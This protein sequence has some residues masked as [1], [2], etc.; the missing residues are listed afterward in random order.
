VNGWVEAFFKMRVIALD[1]TTRAGSA[2]L[3]DDDR[4]VDQRSGDGE[5]THALRL[6][7]EILAI[8]EANG[9]AL[10][11]VDLYAVAS[12][13]GSFTGLRIGIATIQGLAFVHR[14]PTVAVTALDAIAHAVSGEL[15]PGSVVAAWMDAHRHD[16]FAA[17][18]RVTAAPA[19]T[20]ERLE[21]IEG[22]TVGDPASTLA[23]WLGPLAAVPL[24]FAGDG[25]VMYAGDISRAVPAAHIVPPP[26]LAGAV[27]RL[28]ASRASRGE[29]IEPTALLPLYVRRPDVE[30]AREGRRPPSC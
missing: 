14:R 9:V 5:R 11:S 29:T 15:P 24:V 16:V 26:L 10:S 18:Y 7:G 12:G 4:I 8:A 1:T 22:P 28:A 19:F 23:R 2:A 21:V 27:G 25:A 13:P 30:V 3:V 20:P 6:P 17:L